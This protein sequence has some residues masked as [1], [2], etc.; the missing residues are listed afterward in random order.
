MDCSYSFQDLL[1]NLRV[2][3][4]IPKKF[5]YFYW[6]FKFY[7]LPNMS[8]NMSETTKGDTLTGD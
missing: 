6:G 8:H 7:P 5:H 2:F 1:K 4:K 3:T